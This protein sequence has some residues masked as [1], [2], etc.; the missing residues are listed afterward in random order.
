MEG[1]SGTLRIRIGGQQELSTQGF[2]TTSFP[3]QAASLL[4]GLLTV[5][6]TELTPAGDHELPIKSCPLDDHFLITG[7]PDCRLRLD[8]V[9]LLQVESLGC[10]VRFLDIRL[11][12]IPKGV[13]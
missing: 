13:D 12:A 3:G 7:R 8:R 1:N 10:Y 4:P 9:S 2:N 6:Q 5:T 11:A